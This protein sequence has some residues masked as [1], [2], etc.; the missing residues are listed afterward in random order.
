MI[1][2]FRTLDVSAS[3]S[4]DVCLVGAGAAGIVLALELS[5]AG[6]RVLMLESGDV[7]PKASDQVHNEGEIAG[8]PFTGLISGRVRALGGATRLWFGQCIRLEQI[9]LTQRNW[10]SYSGW[11]ISMADLGPWYERAEQFFHLEGERYDDQ[12]YRNFG[13]SPPAWP[14]GELCT[15]FTI[16]TPRID[17][18][19]LFYREL[20]ENP[21]IRLLVNANVLEVTTA[22]GGVT[23]TGVRVASLDGKMG[24]A[25]APAVVLCCGGI[26]NA[27]LLLLS[28]SEKRD[29]LGN[30][31]NL[32][33]RFLQDHPNATTANVYPADMR[34]LH[35]LFSLQYK[36]A[37][38]YFP[39][40]PLHPRKQQ[41]E[42]CLNC[43]SHL[44]F[45]QDE[46]SGL[47]ACR[48]IYRAVRRKQRPS[49]MS[50]RLRKIA[51][52]LPSVLHA[53][54]TFL[55]KGKSPMG[56]P[57]GVR[58][59]CHTEQQP[60]PESRITLSSDMDMLGMPRARV[61][62]K[63]NETERTAMR[64]MTRSMKCELARL[65]LAEMQIDPWLEDDAADWRNRIADSY[66]HIGAT[67]MASHHGNGVV[68]SNCQVFGTSG[69]FVAGSSVFPTS[70]YANPTLTIVALSLRLA[71]HIREMMPYKS[72]TAGP[73]F[74]VSSD[75]GLKKEIP[76]K[77]SAKTRRY[78]L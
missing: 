18:G 38:R 58:L 30:D 13:L 1:E 69:L 37:L 45:E 7:R 46:D 42:Q 4:A 51:G 34:S 66:H 3:F 78:C 56:R 31:R 8:Q 71:H 40:F 49:Q 55:L 74:T 72:G 50:Q 14:D 28:R 16:Y 17:L 64:I 61:H 77:K 59:Q 29:G 67:R 24:F 5:K 53:G 54:S 10:V 11:P 35:A 32:V 48:E 44:V 47:A 6:L 25:N 21:R 39:K 70:G 33:G 19:H 27:R 52:D 26:E 76:G 23:C 20:K 68:D 2:D 36:G 62:W 12:I 15:H 43:T 57:T 63:V 75:S 60:D 9:D 41:A 22:G 65:G 73:A